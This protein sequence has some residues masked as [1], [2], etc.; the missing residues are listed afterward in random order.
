MISD[1][2]PDAEVIVAASDG[3]TRVAGN[4]GEKAWW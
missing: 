2:M 3:T 1:W 4:E